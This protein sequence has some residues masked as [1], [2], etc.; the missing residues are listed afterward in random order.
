M[1][2]FDV[3][4]RSL[5]NMKLGKPQFLIESLNQQLTATKKKVKTQIFQKR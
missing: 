1:K 5:S 2:P 3:S 4:L